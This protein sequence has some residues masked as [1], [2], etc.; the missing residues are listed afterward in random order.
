M[1]LELTMV[2]VED[3][4]SYVPVCVPFFPPPK[5]IAT[6]PQLTYKW[7]KVAPTCKRYE[8][9]SCKLACTR[10]H[11]QELAWTGMWVHDLACP[12]MLLHATCTNLHCSR[13]CLHACA[14]NLLC[15]L[16]ALASLA[17]TQIFCNLHH[18]HANWTIKIKQNNV[19][20]PVGI[21]ILADEL[22][23]CI[24]YLYTYIFGTRLAIYNSFR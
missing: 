23:L 3:N 2:G 6:F 24:S 17:I 14:C 10:M 1:V 16:D 22:K 11:S 4:A 7:H 13:I 18:L 12:R 21:E 19:H 20:S 15:N 5:T 8:R 9:A